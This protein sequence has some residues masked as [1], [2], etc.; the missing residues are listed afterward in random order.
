MDIVKKKTKKSVSP[1]LFL[2]IVFG[3]LYLV[4]AVTQKHSERV[5]S[6]NS[7]SNNNGNGNGNGYGSGKNNDDEDNNGGYQSPTPTYVQPTLNITTYPTV[8]NSPTYVKTTAI[9][10]TVYL[11]ATPTTQPVLPTESLE[12]STNQ[13]P[14]P[15]NS[16]SGTDNSESGK[17]YQKE[18]EVVVVPVSERSVI[19]TVTSNSNG[20]VVIPTKSIFKKIENKIRGTGGSGQFLTKPKSTVTP[21][22]TQKDDSFN[23]PVVLGPDSSIFYML[24][25]TE[26]LLGAVDKEDKRI[27]V[28]EA[29]LRGAEIT[30]DKVLKKKGLDLGVSSGGSLVLTEN[31]VRSYFQLPVFVDVFSHEISV[32]TASGK[33]QIKTTPAKAIVNAIES[34]YLE[35]IDRKAKITMEVIKGSELVYRVQGYEDFKVFG[36]FDARGT[37]Y[38]YVDVESG[39]VKEGNQPLLSK[40]LKMISL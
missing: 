14:T 12:N 29:E 2:V 19:S 38:V 26:L 23:P 33:K 27:N 5:L 16:S 22:P 18:V 11:T 1:L 15:N 39:E 3:V 25:D 31:G 13:N 4:L 30:M 35:D 36:R 32:D 24:T 28:D 40:V 37:Q 9:Q 10:P 21:T 20:R 6:Y 17:E 8:V 7:G 34:G